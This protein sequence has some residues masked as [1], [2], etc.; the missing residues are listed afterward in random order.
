MEAILES[1]LDFLGDMLG[2]RWIEITAACLGLINVSLIIRRSL[3]NYPFGII[4]VILYG[5]VFWD[6]KLY[7]ESVLQAYFLVIQVFGWLW[8]LK[9]RD[10]NGLIVVTRTPR[11]QAAL[12]LLG[13]MAVAGGLGTILHLYTD[14]TLPFADAAVAALSV[15]AQYLMAQR[16]L[17]SWIIWIAV[18]LLSISLYLSK[19]LY[20][21]A[22][23][24]G[25]FLSMATAGLVSWWQAY[26][27]NQTLNA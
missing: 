1:L 14:A 22:V 21:T 12:S 16:R 11:R 27:R 2:T 15:V 17:E 23:L 18:D 25:L 26:Q 13:T 19:E 7:A 10:E 4:M 24:Y 3:W 8:W 5:W 20:P 6:S 9:G